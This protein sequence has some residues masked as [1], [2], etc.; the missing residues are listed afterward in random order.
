M[1]Y[2]TSRIS[3]LILYRAYSESHILHL[4]SCIFYLRI[5][6]DNRGLVSRASRMLYLTPCIFFNLASH[7]FLFHSFAFFIS[8]LIFF[9]PHNVTCVSMCL[10]LWHMYD[11]CHRHFHRHIWHMTHMTYDIWHIYDTYVIDI[12]IDICHMSTSMSRAQ[13]LSCILHFYLEVNVDFVD[14]SRIISHLPCP[15]VYSHTI[16]DSVSDQGKYEIYFIERAEWLV[17][18][19]VAL[20]VIF[21][22][23]P[24]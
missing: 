20:E 23:V 6:Q 4:A 5:S 8:H 7:I 3:I 12:F 1:F 21:Q 17:V 10:C 2:L 9:M 19:H 18:K 15:L 14:S 16:Q 22:R 24:A 13:F 11:I